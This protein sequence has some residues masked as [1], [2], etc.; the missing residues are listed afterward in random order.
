MWDVLVCGGGTAGVVAGIAA[1]REGVRTLII[2]QFGALGGTQTQGWVTPMM[3]NFIE[4]RHLHGGLDAEL[5]RRHALRHPG[6]PGEWDAQSYY[7]P[8]T[9]ALIYDEIAEEFG[10]SVLFHSHVV[11]VEWTSLPHAPTPHVEGGSWR[12]LVANK[13]GL[14]WLEARIVIDCTGDADVARLAGAETLSGDDEARHQPMTLRFTMANIDEES[15][16]ERFRTGSFL[17]FGTGEA[18]ESTIAEEV[19]QAVRDGV[20]EAGDLGYF[21]FF[22]MLGRPRELAFNCPR[23]TGLD[24]ASAA[25]L[26]AAQRIGRQKIERIANF[27][28]RYLPGFAGS[29]VATIAPMVGVRE[30]RRIVGLHV[31]TEEECLGATKFPDPVARCC[32]PVDVHNPSGPGI[33]IKK[34]PAGDYYEIPYRCLVPAE[35]D[36]MLV[37]G[38]CLSATFNAQSSARI[39]PVCRAM[40]EAAGIAA[41]L[42]VRNGQKPREVRYSD[43]RAKMDERGF[44]DG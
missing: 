29:Y 28:R 11:A 23:I 12:V 40:G 39:Q 15:A 32:Y 34:I 25:D 21:Q 37:A 2:E 33:T 24:G 8:L 7:N 3:P 20:L 13:D 18:T 16:A 10:A 42:C 30:T 6:P 31:L 19:A 1:A 4:Q 38:R 41:A 26:S 27:C 9:M 43:L 36:G 14:S 22:S 17:Y 35:T 5:R 44:F